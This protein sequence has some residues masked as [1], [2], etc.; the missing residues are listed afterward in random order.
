MA[1]YE[2]AWRAAVNNSNVQKF[3]A[4]S[5]Y[6]NTRPIENQDTNFY[7]FPSIIG[8]SSAANNNNNIHRLVPCDNQQEQQSSQ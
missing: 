4:F 2:M 5:S 6:A 7:N 1:Y 8:A 3:N